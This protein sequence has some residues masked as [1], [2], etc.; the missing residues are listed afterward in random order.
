MSRKSCGI[1]N[2][3]RKVKRCKTNYAEG[4]LSPRR[5]C[6]NIRKKSPL[7]ACFDGLPRRSCASSGCRAAGKVLYP[8]LLCLCFCNVAAVG[9]PAEVTA[10]RPLRAPVVELSPPPCAVPWVSRS[11]TGSGSLGYLDVGVGKWPTCTQDNVRLQYKPVSV[12]RRWLFSFMLSDLV[13]VVGMS[14]FP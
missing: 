13:C 14:V 3:T 12:L 6:K 1:K 7:Q 11:S 4:L 9:L 5:K 10:T 2:A 8:L